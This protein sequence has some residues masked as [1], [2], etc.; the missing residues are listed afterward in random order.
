MVQPPEIAK[1]VLVF[2]TRPAFGDSVQLGHRPVRV[3]LPG[4]RQPDRLYRKRRPVQPMAIESDPGGGFPYSIYRFHAH[5][6]Q[7]RAL[8]DKPSDRFCPF[9][10]GRLLPV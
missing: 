1:R 7:E 4:A 8:A 5:F 3:L 6:L 9:D 2:E 10:F